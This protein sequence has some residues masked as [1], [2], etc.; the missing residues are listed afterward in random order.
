MAI[1]A[2]H[3]GFTLKESVK[4][5]LLAQGH[6]VLDVGTSSTDSVDYPDYAALVGE[7]V[8]GGAAERGVLMCGTGIGMAIAA[9][10]IP[11]VRAAVCGDVASARICREH[12]DA[13]VLA[14]GARAT[15]REQA[16]QIIAA[17]LATAFAGGRHARRV[18]K[19]MGL[20]QRDVS[21]VAA[22]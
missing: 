18:E 7:A 21:R 22:G 1:G 17:W 8:S 20:E 9:N 12:N 3:A 4:S 19:V 2:D 10:K 16:L 5:W 14:L 13:N 15:E 11:G 6:T